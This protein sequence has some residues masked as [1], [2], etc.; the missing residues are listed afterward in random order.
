MTSG[1]AVDGVARATA[2]VA[3]AEAA[4]FGSFAA[5]RA[6]GPLSVLGAASTSGSVAMAVV[7]DARRWM[8]AGVPTGVGV[9][10]VAAGF[11]GAD[12][13]TFVGEPTDG[14]DAPRA[15]GGVSDTK[16]AC[17]GAVV[18]GV[19]GGVVDTGEAAAVDVRLRSPV[20]G[21][22]AA[23]GISAAGGGWSG[24]WVARRWIAAG[25]PLLAL[26]GAGVALDGGG[27]AWFDGVTGPED[28]GAPGPRERSSGRSKG[29]GAVPESTELLGPGVG[30]TDTG[31]ATSPGACVG[32]VGAAARGIDGAEVVDGAVRVVVVAG[33]VGVPV[34]RRCVPA[35]TDPDDRSGVAA[36]EVIAC[37]VGPEGADA[38]PGAD[39]V[40]SGGGGAVVP[41]GVGVP[42]GRR[43]AAGE[44][45][46]DE[47]AGVGV[48]PAA[49]V[50]VGVVPAAD[51]AAG[52]DPAEAELLGSRARS[53]GPRR[54]A[55]PGSPAAAVAGAEVLGASSRDAG[56]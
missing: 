26:R 29:A 40:T 38:G 5:P 18:A 47:G 32:A 33:G 27:G 8:V 22:G 44:A 2:G 46:S 53:L 41:E 34:A 49:G 50:A 28:D 55:A 45:A 4:E 35:G 20:E 37:P 31:G 12:A 13:P 19:R 39:A 14:V 15:S 42:V 23:A 36:G 54:G 30:V 11:T 48:V 24:V 25:V 52:V 9:P 56:A 10:G 3:V 43:G 51:V 7:V 16:G 1:G 6:L 17:A 21:C